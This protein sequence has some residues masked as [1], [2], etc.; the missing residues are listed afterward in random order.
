[1]LSM[2]RLPS[3][4]HVVRSGEVP[5]HYDVEA[6]REIVKRA[7]TLMRTDPPKPI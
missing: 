7:L 3:V 4:V 2:S 1:M 6:M 5:S